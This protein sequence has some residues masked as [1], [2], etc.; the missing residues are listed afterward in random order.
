MQFVEKSLADGS[1]SGLKLPW[2]GAHNIEGGFNVFRSNMGNDG[3][4]LPRHRYPLLPGSDLSAAAGGYHITYGSSWMFALEFTD[5][6]PVAEGLLSYSQSSNSES[7]H[8]I[9]QTLLYSS[10]PQLRPL[11]FHQADIDAHTEV[12]LQLTGSSQ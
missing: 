6:G 9:D 3:T 5:D 8:F 4:V 1:A 11:Y 7:D 10:E 12:E 2:G